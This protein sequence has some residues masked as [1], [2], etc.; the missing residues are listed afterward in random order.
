MFWV[1]IARGHG[2]SDVHRASVITRMHNSISH[3]ILREEDLRNLH[4]IRIF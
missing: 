2:S 3:D 1:V 4:S